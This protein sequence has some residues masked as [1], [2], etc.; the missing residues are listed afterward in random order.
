MLKSSGRSAILYLMMKYD[1]FLFYGKIGST[2]ELVF[3]GHRQELAGRDYQVG[4]LLGDDLLGV[5]DSQGEKVCAFL[6]VYQ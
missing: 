2:L 5:K 4:V 6:L 1:T 3:K